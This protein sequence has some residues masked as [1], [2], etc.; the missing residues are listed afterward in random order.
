MSFVWVWFSCVPPCASLL[1][2][3][4]VGILGVNSNFV[5]HQLPLSLFALACIPGVVD[6]KMTSETTKKILL[7][8]KVK[9]S[10]KDTATLC[11]CAAA[12]Y[13]ASIDQACYPIGEHTLHVFCISADEL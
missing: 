7:I 4:I 6:V 11:Q 12:L 9:H 13:R 5:C 10:A 8:S 1:S 2:S 3:T